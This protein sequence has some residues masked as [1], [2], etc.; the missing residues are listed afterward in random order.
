MTKP[1][2]EILALMVVEERIALS[3]EPPI[4]D[5]YMELAAWRAMYKVA[6]KIPSLRASHMAAKSAA[7]KKAR[8]KLARQHIDWAIEDCISR[9][10]VP[11]LESIKTS[12]KKLKDSQIFY[13]DEAAAY[14]EKLAR[15]AI[16]KPN[17]IRMYLQEL[18]KKVS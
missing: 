6:S 8:I 16:V 12:L 9:K 1:A 13:D 11:N 7:V 14:D 4:E 2:H 15:K 18:R 17:T 10:I 3:K 5:I